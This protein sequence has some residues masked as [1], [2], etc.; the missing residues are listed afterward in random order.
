LSPE[1]ILGRG[2]DAR[3]DLFALGAVLYEMCTGVRAFQ[4]GN[5]NEIM[6]GIIHRQPEAIGRHTYEV[7]E[8]LERIVRKC[9]RKRP[10]ERYQTAAELRV[11]LAALRREEDFRDYSESHPELAGMAAL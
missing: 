6:D 3:S 10:Q 9:L 7:P 5:E 1:Q 11:D 4:G 2:V 8:E